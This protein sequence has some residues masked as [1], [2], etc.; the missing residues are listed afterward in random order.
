MRDRLAAASAAVNRVGAALAAVALS[1]L[2]LLI[3]LGVVLRRVFGA[4]LVFTDEFSAYLLVVVTYLGLGYAM[5]HG[6]HI[7][8]EIVVRRLRPRAL[9][10]LRVAWS[11][12][13]LVFTG[14][15]TVRTAVLAL[16]SLR[17]GRVS[18]ESQVVLAPIQAIAPVG[19]ALLFVG[20]AVQLLDAV[21][22]RE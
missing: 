17:I 6:D 4:P 11:V 22:G 20:L 16:D 8:V 15:L 13:G 21:A 9:R 7:Q 12:V 3:T 1:A 5:Q 18:I 14:L 2:A 19:L 10:W